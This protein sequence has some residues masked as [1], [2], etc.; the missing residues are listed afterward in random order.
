MGNIST[1]QNLEFEEIE[2][3]LN[4]DENTQK[5]PTFEITH[6]FLSDFD[7]EIDRDDFF[8]DLKGFIA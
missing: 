4:E 8:S 5:S 2:E 7:I 1:Q 3:N 6:N